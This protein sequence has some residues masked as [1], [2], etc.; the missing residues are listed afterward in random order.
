MTRGEYAEAA[1]PTEIVLERIGVC[2]CADCHVFV[3]YCGQSRFGR[4]SRSARSLTA[5]A[6]GEIN[7][8]SAMQRD[9]RCRADPA[10]RPWRR[11]TGAPAPEAGGCQRILRRRALARCAP[12]AEHGPRPP[13]AAFP[14]RPPPPSPPPPHPPP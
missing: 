2:L 1:H 12:R 10:I 13:P 7:R 3:I 11:Q 9:I 14:P 6:A 4:L 8:V 5:T